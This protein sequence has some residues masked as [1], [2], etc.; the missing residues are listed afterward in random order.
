M[1]EGSSGDPLT[2]SPE[3]SRVRPCREVSDLVVGWVVAIGG[4][5]QHRGDRQVERLEAAF[6]QVARECLAAIGVAVFAPREGRHG[7]AARHTWW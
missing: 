1:D 5:G 2:P 7:D 4:V 6:R 3:E